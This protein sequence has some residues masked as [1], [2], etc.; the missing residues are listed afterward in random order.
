MRH[1]TPYSKIEQPSA[2]DYGELVRVWEGAVRSTHHFLC[3][4]DIAHIRAHLP[5]DYFPAVELYGIRG[6]GG[7]WAAF[8]GLST[9]QIEMLF[10]DPRYQRRGLGRRLLALATGEKGLRRIECNE[11]NEAGLAFYRRMGFEVAGRLP[12]D[13]EGR[14][15]PLL[16][17]YY[18]PA[19]P[20]RIR[21]EQRTVERMVR[22]YCRQAEGHAELCPVCHEL[23]DYARA[24]LARCPH[25][26]AK[27]TCQRCPIHCYRPDMR[28]RMRRVMRFAGPRM[29]FHHPVAALRHLLRR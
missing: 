26:A 12:L 13:H 1:D 6:D 19:L 25:G 7:Q 4:A 20:R 8:M 9:E 10:V 23:L 2:A 11:Q 5:T 22:L 14:P 28:E 16:Q 15:Y 27:P 21:R 17:L 24:R 18:A 3:E 29:L